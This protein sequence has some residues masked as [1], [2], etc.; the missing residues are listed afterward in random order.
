[1][2]HDSQPYFAPDASHEWVETD[3]TEEANTWMKPMTKIR[4]SK[5]VEIPANWHLDDWPPLQPMP[6]RA[7]TVSCISLD[8]SYVTA[9]WLIGIYR[10]MGLLVR[11]KWKDYGLNSLTLHMKNTIASY[12]LCLFIPKSVGSHRLSRCMNGTSCILIDR[13]GS[14]TYLASSITSTNMK[15]SSGCRSVRWRKSFSKVGSKESRLKEEP[16]W[17]V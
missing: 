13:Q 17:K 14:L 12:F 16:R 2:H 5:I 8:P 7:G 1:M 3:I 15:E 4:A 9:S 11:M 6:G 10:S